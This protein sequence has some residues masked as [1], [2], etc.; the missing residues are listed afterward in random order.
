MLHIPTEYLHA[1]RIASWDEYVQCM[2]SKVIS[3]PS[4]LQAQNYARV[5]GTCTFKHPRT[6]ECACIKFLRTCVRLD[7]DST[8]CY[9]SVYDIAW[10]ST[11]QVTALLMTCR[12]CVVQRQI[13]RMGIVYLACPTSM[14]FAGCAERDVLKNSLCR[15]KCLHN[16]NVVYDRTT[17]RSLLVP[18][19]LFDALHVCTTRG[20]A[21]DDGKGYV[22]PA[23]SP[24]RPAP[25]AAAFVYCIR[26]ADLLVCL[27]CLWLLSS[28]YVRAPR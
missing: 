9:T 13:T 27:L 16:I 20:V 21:R 7:D 23:S 26:F 28:D 5:A 6:S 4:T 2:E 18:M 8:I 19:A 12:K 22:W 24:T 11:E 1:L 14:A 25:I 3:V 15:H 17:H 10:N